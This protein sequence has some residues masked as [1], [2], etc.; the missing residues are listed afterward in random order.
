[1]DIETIMETTHLKRG[2]NKSRLLLAAG[3]AFLALFIA[4][5]CGKKAPEQPKMKIPVTTGEVT[6]ADFPVS[7]NTFGTLT[8]IN[9]VD[10]KAQVSGKI[11]EARFIEGQT[12]KAGDILYV[13]EKPPFEAQVE[14]AKASLRMDEGYLDYYKYLVDVN[15]TLADTSALAKQ[16][17]E[18]YVSQF[19]VYTGKTENDKAQLKTAQINLNWCEIKA[20]IDGI[21]GKQL[22]DPGNIVSTADNPALVNIKSLDPIY[23]DLTIP[24]KHFYN[25]K[26]LF[27]KGPV[28]IIATTQGDPNSYEGTVVLLNNSI[29]TS[30]GTLSVRAS[31]PNP[32]RSLWPGQFIYVKVVLNVLSGATMVPVNAV[33]NNQNGPF[34]YVM[35]DGKADVVPVVTGQS[36]T[37]R[38]VILKGDIKPGERVINAGTLMLS[39]GA[40]VVEAQDNMKAMMAAMAAKA[41][42]KPGAPGA[43]AAGQKP[44]QA[45]PA[46]AQAKKQ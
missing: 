31:I 17:Y 19:R 36:N 25:V 6:T 24:E 30:S 29:D 41:G 27:D 7:I 4:S 10:V 16:T 39:P 33:Q 43:P 44:E 14:G 18:Q 9:D 15:K 23:A 3:G 26:S 22:I 2:S 42:Q 21:T 46:E 32:K 1:M 8:A 5:A 11:I 45:K 20:P 40:E 12:V 34:V 37:D 38:T 28:K 35:R 13:I